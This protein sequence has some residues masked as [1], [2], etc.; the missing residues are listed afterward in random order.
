[1]AHNDL[2]V[3]SYE[4]GDKEAAVRHYSEAAQ[5]EPENSVYL[6]NLADFL[7]IEKGDIKA[8]LQKYV[9]ALTLD[10]EDC[11]ALLATGHI[12]LGVGQ[13]EDAGVFF[14]RVLQIDPWNQEARQ[15][16]N[17]SKTAPSISFAAC[18]DED[19][20][21]RAQNEVAEGKR[22]RAAETLRT[23]IAQS[24]DHALAYNDLGVLS[25]DLGDKKAAMGFYE[26]ACRLEPDNST[27][28]KN[29]ADFYFVEQQRTEDALKIYVRLLEADKE[30]LDCLMAAGTICASLD[31][32]QD[33]DLFFRRVLEI[34]PWNSRARDAL[35]QVEHMQVPDHNF[36]AFN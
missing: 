29:L 22:E 19:L 3:L 14:D 25:Y 7:Y 34:D 9:Q 4:Q 33:A 32:V 12:C 36:A 21:A 24:P 31:R 6:K 18:S 13:N 15:L 27:F 11:E 8:A 10:P 35:Q 17:Q 1:M 2:A 23:L 16:L 26:Q 30:D 20:Y 5:L 28:L